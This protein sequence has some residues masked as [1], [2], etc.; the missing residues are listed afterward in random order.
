MDL[1]ERKT[2]RGKSIEFDTVK[3][4]VLLQ[5]DNEDNLISYVNPNI[6][7]LEEDFLSKKCYLEYFDCQNLRSIGP[8]GLYNISS[9]NDLIINL[10]SLEVTADNCFSTV[11]CKGQFKLHTPSWRHIGNKNFF[12]TKNIENI[13]LY[14]P[15][16]ESI[17]SG[18]FSDVPIRSLKADKLRDVGNCSLEMFA[19]ESI[20]LPSL[21]HGGYLFLGGAP[22]LKKANFPKLT[23]LGEDALC[24]AKNLETLIAP[25]LKVIQNIEYYHFENLRNIDSPYIEKFLSE[26]RKELR[27]TNLQEKSGKSIA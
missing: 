4:K 10:P 15:S 26:R 17:G 27:S 19:G 16:M 18:C 23:H 7:R 5:L 13:D 12:Y 2:K 24:K 21:E 8:R 25:N 11:N 14:L 6:T 3:G 22:Y 20:S 9:H 1:N